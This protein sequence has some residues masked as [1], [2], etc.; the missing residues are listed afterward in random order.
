MAVFGV[1]NY[2]DEVK[3]EELLAERR[4]VFENSQQ[5]YAAGSIDQALNLLNSL[6]IFYEAEKDMADY[7]ENLFDSIF[8]NGYASYQS[9]DYQDAI[10]YMELIEKYAENKPI[11]IK[12]QLAYAYKFTDQ[13][14]KSIRKLHELLLMD[15]RTLDVYMQLAEI[16]R[17]QMNDLNEARRFLEIADE[18]T[19]SS[20]RAIYGD[21]FPLVLTGEY[22]P[23]EHYYLYTNLADIYLK[24][25]DAEKAVKATRWNIRMWPDSISN[26][27]IAAKGHMAQG[28]QINACNFYRKAK[29]LGYGE[30]LPIICY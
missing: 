15:V 16:Y 17:D 22:V 9:N 26:Y 12:Q 14:Q 1:K 20:Y 25:G 6:G 23:K 21:G 28:N 30:R 19:V 7:K 18:M 27:L 24:T 2:Y 29:A 10:F 4:S 13:P 11:A 3:K 5:L 8:T